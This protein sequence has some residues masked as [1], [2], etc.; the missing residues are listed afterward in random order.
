M[1][2]RLGVGEATGQLCTHSGRKHRSG[3][4]RLRLR[5]PHGQ[6]FQRRS[7]S[8]PPPPR[9]AADSML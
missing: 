5:G 6:G 2:A 9:G 8:R 4:Q 3:W 1:P 7:L